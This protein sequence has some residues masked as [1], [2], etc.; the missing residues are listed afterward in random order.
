MR[1]FRIRNIGYSLL[2]ILAGLLAAACDD[3]DDHAAVLSFS[4][5]IYILPANAT[6]EVELRAS[7]APSGELKVPISIEGSAVLGEDF[8]ISSREFT[9]KSGE[10]RAVVNLTPKNNLEE[11]KEIRLSVM[12]VEGY[13]LGERRVAIIPV[14][15]KEHVMY[16]FKP[17][18]FRLLSEIDVWVELQ[19]ENTGTKFRASH[20]I[21]IPLEIDKESTAVLGTDFELENDMTQVLIPKGER[22]VHFKIR[23]KEG[24]E[25]FAGKTAI[26][27]LGNPEK[28]TDLY[29]EGSFVTYNIKLD[30]L[31]FTDMLGKWK[32][33]EILYKDN[34]EFAEIP[35]ED[36][37]NSLP[38]KNNDNDYLEFIHQ[39][40]KDLI[41]PHLTGDLKAFFCNQEGH[42]IIFDHVEKG[43]L[44][45]ATF[46]EYDVPY[47]VAHQVNKL[48]SKNKIEKGNV[49]LGL[50]KV[51]ENHI[52]VYFHEYIPTDFFRATYLEYDGYFDASFF[53]IT[54]SFERISD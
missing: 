1:N 22:Q 48:F 27:K 46:E 9:F 24:A 2:V 53:G 35:K 37:V 5:S 28:G 45:W 38:E 11:N 13:A 44:N 8:E 34:Y 54:Y 14:E 16:T 3:N 20:D 4:R 17:N 19:G 30:Q 6:L 39:G 49:F 29:Y 41:V 33:V 23:V 42:E 25:D 18:Q 43:L 26:L 31:K 47:F 51:D 10:A 12:P 15:V 21:I 52:L 36:Y 32:P 50:D 40:G 7:V